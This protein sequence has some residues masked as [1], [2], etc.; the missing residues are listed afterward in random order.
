[1]RYNPGTNQWTAI[2]TLPEALES[3]SAVSDGTYIYVMGGMTGGNALSTLRRYDPVANTYTT[4][5]TMP[6]G[7]WSMA[8]A[9]LNGKIYRIGGCVVAGCN[10]TTSV[11]VYTIVSNTWAAGPNYPIFVAQ[12]TGVALGGFIYVAGGY[13]A[14]LAT[15]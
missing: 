6:V 11:D 5:A 1:Y 12:T 8:A 15:T 7:A 4:L 14:P 13:N 10:G 3:A 9:Y 2:A